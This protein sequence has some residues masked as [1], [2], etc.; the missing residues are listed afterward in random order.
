LNNVC[1][2][3]ENRLLTDRSSYQRDDSYQVP[4]WLEGDRI[5]EVMFCN[6]F[7][8][9]HPIVFVKGKYYDAEQIVDEEELK[10]EIYSH[11]SPF[12]TENVSRTVN[13][14]SSL[15]KIRALTR[16][17]PIQEDRIHFRN[18]IYYLDD[19]L[20]TEEKEICL[21]PLPINYNPD[22]A[23][24]TLW[25]SFLHELLHEEDIPALQ[26]FMGYMLIPTTRAHKMLLIIGKG[27]EGKSR[28]AR[29]IK[30]IL[31]NNMNTSSL[32]KLAGN[33]FSRADQAGK[34]LMLD[35]EIKTEKMPDVEMLKAIVTSEDDMD[36]E[37]KGVQSYQD[38]LYVRLI[39]F[40]NGRLSA[41]HDRSDGF[42]R[43]QLIIKTISK[44]A[45]RVDDTFLG[46]KLVEEAEGILLWCLEGLHR[47]RDNGFHFTISTRMK[48]NLEEIREDDN[49]II[50]F[51]D[52]TG[53]IEY[54]RTASSTTDQLYMVYE[55]WCAANAEMPQTKT[56][57]G[58]YM[59]DVEE[60]LGIEYKK[61]I[62]NG[63][64][65][66]TRGYKGVRITVAV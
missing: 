56:M 44:P 35:D 32:H 64:G 4:E 21:N 16:E 51:L 58:R 17:L 33:R 11:I 55:Q 45:N 41:I 12:I 50:G 47:L 14:L 22:A 66:R 18:G 30:R 43:R 52:S 48:K 23:P 42:Y 24:P 65:R 61:N 60:T 28:I 5:N 7:I 54:D 3:T 31:G 29:V 13:K 37:K 49:N 1:T 15:M 19:R 25:L 36:V 59:R 46:D 9:R 2:G 34:L 38:R 63:N 40:G 6:M 62:D 26:E 53:F 8:Q 57:F 20:F 39:G 27:G 10:H